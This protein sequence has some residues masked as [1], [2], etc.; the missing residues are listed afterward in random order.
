MRLLLLCGSIFIAAT[1]L[2]QTQKSSDVA[3]F[4]TVDTPVFIL[5]HVRVIDGTGAAAKE[6]QAVVIANGKIQ[7][8]GR[9]RPS[10]SLRMRSNSSAPATP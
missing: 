5:K 6:D 3:P 1:A 7:S 8:I 4:V 10:K 9:L 2:A